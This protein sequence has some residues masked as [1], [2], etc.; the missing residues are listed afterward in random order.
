MADM[1]THL[2]VELELFHTASGTAFADVV[3]D[4]H[5]E[6]WPIRST[7]FRSWLKRQYYEETGGAPTITAIR[8]ALDL[9]EVRAQ[10]DGPQRTVHI[11][12]AAHQGRIYLDL[13][14]EPWRAVEIGPDG[15]QVV[16]R[17]P[18]RFRRAAGM[19][20]L[21]VPSKGGSIEALAPFLNLTTQSDF[22][23]VVAW[24]LAALRH[25]GPYPLLAVSGEQGSS[26]TVLSKILRAL[27]DPNV[28]SVRS[29]PRE[30]RDLF[31]AATN[32]HLL[33]F[34]NFSEIPS[35]MSDA[36]CR[37]ASGGSFA[38]RQLYT[39]QDEMLFRAARPAILNGIEDVITRPDLADRAI[40]LTLPYVH[41]TRRR[42]EV[43]IWTEFETARPH[44]LGALLDAASHG[45]RALPDVRLKR[46]PRMADFALWATAC[47]T[48]LWPAGTF[49]RAY[50]ENRKAATEDVIEAD[51][52]A[53]HIR[54]MMIKHTTW[55]GSASDLLRVSSEFSADRS[56]KNAGWPKS[57]R[58]MAGR[59]RRA[60]TSLRV[61]GIDIAFTRE[62]RAGTRIIR[63]NASYNNPTRETVSA[64]S[65]NRRSQ[66]ANPLP[67]AGKPDHAV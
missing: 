59:L 62:G 61:L 40:F 42:P 45:L 56:T 29:A 63:M 44:I 47:E 67:G 11:R 7:R 30:E 21:P 60:Q 53:A 19:L 8:A 25:G 43:E 38:V 39:D 6:T 55:T 28:A 52:V 17:P 33:A 26:K 15:W 35:W 46:L 13:A 31:I 36:L 65:V 5:P 41:E 34:D 49:L 54:E 48:A 9:L 24:L 2:A 32:G 37:L 10:F 1:L 58:A 3:I 27:V 22:V 50:D 51:P 20:P 23:L 66:S 57:P 16:T 64:V 18:V 12:T 14:D 4:G